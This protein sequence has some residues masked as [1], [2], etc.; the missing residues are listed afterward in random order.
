MHFNSSDDLVLKL[1]KFDAAPLMECIKKCAFRNKSPKQILKD[2][3]DKSIYRAF[4][5]ETPSVRYQNWRLHNEVDKLLEKL[6]RVNS[7]SDFDKIVYCLGK[8]LVND[9]GHT[10][11]NGDQSRMNIGIA[12]KITNIVLKNLTLSG[13][14]TNTELINFLHVPWDSYTLRPIRAIFEGDIPNPLGQGSVSNLMLYK[15]LYNFINNISKKSG[16]PK[17]YYELMTWDEQH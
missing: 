5:Y 15:S 8:S 14:V 11:E 7:Q 10:N 16:T 13:H 6:K 3:V 17:I 9:W 2:S 12:M 1:K 4:R